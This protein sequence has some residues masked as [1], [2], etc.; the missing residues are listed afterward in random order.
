MPIVI[1]DSVLTAAHLDEQEFKRE[2]A[3]MLF[4][5]DRL[6]LATAAK[7]AGMPY[8]DFQALLADREISVHYG[9]EELEQDLAAMENRGIL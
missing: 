6:T 2:V 9:I 1:D 8:M 7:L 5:Q 4:A 3:V